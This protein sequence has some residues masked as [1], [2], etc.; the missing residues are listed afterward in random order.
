MKICIFG[1]S[2]TYAGYIN[3]SWFNMLRSELEARV[4]DVE[5]FNLGIN[6]NTSNDILYRFEVEAE[7]RKPEK[8]IFA[9][10]VND[11]GYIFSTNEPLVTEELFRANVTKLTEL[12]SKYT[13]DI[14]FIG[15]VLGDDSILKP[16]PESSKGKSYDHSRTVDYDKMLKDIA[17]KNNCKFIY[18]F[19][20]LDFAD[21]SD[22]LHPNENGHKKMFEV[23]S[24][25][26]I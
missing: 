20:K 25:E 21:F 10:G 9:F 12:A 19:D 17:N 7:S 15:L 18:L 22:G 23:I 14:T 4:D 2:V 6:G 26:L 24:K 16:F 3:N 11:S 5:V 8:I 13:K 1:D